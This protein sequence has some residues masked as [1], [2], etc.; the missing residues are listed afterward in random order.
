MAGIEARGY[1]DYQQPYLHERIP[2]EVSSLWSQNTSQP[3]REKG[4]RHLTAVSPINNE[5]NKIPESRPVGFGTRLSDAR[6]I[7]LAT[8]QRN[9]KEVQAYELE[10]DAV[11]YRVLAKEKR[12][13]AYEQ[14]KESLDAYIKMQLETH[15]GERLHVGISKFVYHIVDGELRTEDTGEPVLAM[16]ERGR[17]YRRKK[18]KPVDWDRE[19]AEVTGLGR[20]QQ[21]LTMSDE[22]VPVGTKMV[23][24]SPQG[25]VENGSIYKQNFYE[26]QEKMADGTVEAYRYTSGLTPEETQEKLTELDSRYKRNTVPTDAEFL[27]NPIQIA[28][29]AFGLHT[30]NDIHE[31]MHKDHKHMSQ[32]DFAIVRQACLPI[33]NAY[34]KALTENPDDTVQQNKLFRAL[35][36]YADRV[37]KELHDDPQHNV[38][39]FTQSPE[40]DFIRPWVAPRIDIN[41]LAQEKVRFVDTGCGASG[42]ATSATSVGEFGTQSEPGSNTCSDCGGDASDNHYHCPEADCA[43]WYADETNVSADKRTKKC[44]CGFEFG[45]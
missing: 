20:I 8:E 33:I 2:T 7:F 16:I 19:D 38:V 11:L 10:Q 39:A 32:K 44:N 22:A 41:A 6:D 3:E 35:L 28:P 27:A 34:T 21:T 37:A 14:S 42:D 4:L 13:E 5:V 17:D 36:N 29:G 1:S 40:N 43:K 25:D 26:V 12:P 30:P 24:A 23:F 45:C 18:G 31:F 9:T 15:L